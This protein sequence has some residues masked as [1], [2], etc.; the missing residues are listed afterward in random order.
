MSGWDWPVW[1]M[2]QGRESEGAFAPFHFVEA[3]VLVSVVLL[4]CHCLITLRW[5]T[6]VFV[7]QCHPC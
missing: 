6:A 7:F 4:H 2:Q 5:D 3:F 1:D